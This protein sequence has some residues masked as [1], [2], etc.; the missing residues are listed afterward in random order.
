MIKT[1]VSL[2]RQGEPGSRG[3]PGP[4][5]KPGPPVSKCHL[6]CLREQ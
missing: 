5:G 1:N 4:V 3:F 6:S 2:H